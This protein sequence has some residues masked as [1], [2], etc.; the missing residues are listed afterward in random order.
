VS[1]LDY[2]LGGDL[3]IGRLGFGAMRITGRDVWGDPADPAAMRSLLRHVVARGVTLIDTA[4]SY[5]PETSENL[6][7]EALHPYPADLVIAT[8][9]GYTRSAANITRWGTDCRPE[10]LKACC[11]GSLR[12]LGVERIDLFQLHAVDP[13]VPIEESVGALRELRDAGAIRHIGLSNVTVE[14]MRRAQQVAPIASVQNRYNVLQ[15][16]SE[17]VLEACEHD[18][19]A[20]LPYSPLGDGSLAS[21]AGPVREVADALGVT[22]GQVALAWLLA[23]SRVTVPIPG[24]GSIEHF[25]ENLAAADVPLQG[26]HMDALS[27]V[28]GAC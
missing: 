27:A 15:R 7:R 20:F 25:D 19:I 4:D 6:I 2:T 13:R 11:E 28:A 16:D 26:A 10:R 8:K 12:R 24:T 5:G 3:R 9:A 1:G 17:D 22:P 18:G 21:G 14:E 23:R